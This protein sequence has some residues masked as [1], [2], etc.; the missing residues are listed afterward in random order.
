[1][2]SLRKQFRHVTLDRGPLEKIRVYSGVQHGGIGK[3]EITKVCFVEQTLFAQLIGFGQHVVHIEHV[4]V[5][6]V[7]AEHCL[8]PG[9][10]GIFALVEGPR[11]EPVVSFAT[12]IEIRLEE[13]A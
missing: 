12:K 3:G 1:M 4:P 2:R 13:L 8:Q 11:G 10:K 5:T 9:A 6:Q 7:G